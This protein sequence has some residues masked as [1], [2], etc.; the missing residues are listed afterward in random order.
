MDYASSYH[1]AEGFLKIH[2]T[3]SEAYAFML[4]PG[5]HAHA[6]LHLMTFPSSGKVNVDSALDTVS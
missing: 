5:E 6:L 4:C 2:E 3:Q 1:C